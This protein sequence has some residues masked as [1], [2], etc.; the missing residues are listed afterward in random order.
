[1]HAS[2]YLPA[3]RTVWGLKHNMDCGTL[4]FQSCIFHS[5]LPRELAREV[6]Q[7]LAAERP[8]QERPAC[9]ANRTSRQAEHAGATFDALTRVCMDMDACI[10]AG[11]DGIS[12][13]A[14]KCTRRTTSLTGCWQALMLQCRATNEACGW[15]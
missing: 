3:D 13:R 7:S 12:V 10:D 14:V 4:S 15:D 9:G 2:L 6:G 8:Q 11:E 5:D 1:M